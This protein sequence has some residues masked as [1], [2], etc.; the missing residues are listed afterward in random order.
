MIS[1]LESAGGSPNYYA[2][3]GAGH[4]WNQVWDYT[5]NT[6]Y[7]PD[8]IDWMFAQSKSGSTSLAHHHAELHEMRK[9]D[10][11]KISAKAGR[12]SALHN[13]NMYSINGQHINGSMLNAR[14]L[15]QSMRGVFI[16]RLRGAHGEAKACAPMHI[17]K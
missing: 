6:F 15:P 5:D 4:V 7:Q 10:F 16:V 3:Q 1:A 11:H 2:F 8:L 13:L 17:L 12:L 9:P 14:I